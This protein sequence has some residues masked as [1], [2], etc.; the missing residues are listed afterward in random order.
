MAAMTA[1]QTV[2]E[3]RQYT[4]HPGQREV[5]VELFDARLIESQEAVGISVIGQFRDLDRPDR[6][7][8][9]RGFDDMKVRARS[10]AE[11]YGGP[12]WRAN[13]AEANATMVDT[14]DVLLLRPVGPGSTFRLN[15]AT[16]SNGAAGFVEATILHLDGAD[17]AAAVRG[18]EQEVAPVIAESG[19]T[20]LGYFVTEPAENTFPRLPVR[21]GEDVLVW[22]AGFA[23][24]RN[25]A[26]RREAAMRLAPKRRLEV[27]RLEPTTRSLLDGQSSP[28]PERSAQ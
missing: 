28:Q 23:E 20:L 10:L 6:F 16:R 27:L 1:R 4:L 18:L 9:L 7:V 19:G 21:E 15:D 13:S 2:V 11:F 12:V 22:F 5:L 3:L 24:R 26:A 14:D 8:W 17:Q 25:G